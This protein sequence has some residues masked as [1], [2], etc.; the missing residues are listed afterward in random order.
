MNVTVNDLY[1]P[2]CNQIAELIYH[3][4][5]ET[6]PISQTETVTP[7]FATFWCVCCSALITADQVFAYNN[8][9]AD[10]FINLVLTGTS[11]NGQITLNWTI[12]NVEQV[13][14]KIYRSNSAFLGEAAE[15]GTIA[16]NTMTYIDTPSGENP[17]YYYW[18]IVTD[19]AGNTYTSIA[20]SVTAI[21]GL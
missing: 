20:V 11:E 18:V 1:C 4:A 13:S 10:E 8:I 17:R 7:D 6:I 21:T 3:P 15:V 12:E 5:G 9:S 2:V 19:S 14:A 16:D